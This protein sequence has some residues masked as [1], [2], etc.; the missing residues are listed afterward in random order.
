MLVSFGLDSRLS[1]GAGRLERVHT[2]RQ[3]HRAS[4]A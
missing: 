1:I 4:Q 2:A 3:F